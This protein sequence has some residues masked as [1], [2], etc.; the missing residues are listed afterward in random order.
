[1][2][3]SS[4]PRRWFRALVVVVTLAQAGCLED[5]TVGLVT[6]GLVA[7]AG[8]SRDGGPGDTRDAG[9]LA[10]A[11]AP[12]P[13]AGPCIPDDCSP[14]TITTNVLRTGPDSPCATGEAPSCKRGAGG[15]CALQCPAIPP[16]VACDGVSFV[17]D[18]SCTGPTL[19]CRREHGACSAS[20]QGACSQRPTACPQE[21]D[22]V[23]G[24]DGA[25][26]DN[27]CRAFSMGTNVQARGACP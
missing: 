3:R 14:I 1:M 23:C 8:G 9:P 13:D 22:P 10:D 24:C 19:F 4:C 20:I 16:D 27:A 2:G 6:V 11:S 18:T 25:T 5:A 21:L 26:Y 12:S 7:D 17:R 15:R